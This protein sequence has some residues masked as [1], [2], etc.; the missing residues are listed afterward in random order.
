MK[1]FFLLIAVVVLLSSCS[2]KKGYKVTVQYPAE[3]NEMGYLL[4]VKEGALV[5]VDSSLYKGNFVFNGEVEQPEMYY[6]KT[7]NGNDRYNFFVENK[8]FTVHISKDENKVSSEGSPINKT[9]EQ[10]LDKTSIFMKQMDDLNVAYDEA[11]VNDKISALDSINQLADKIEMEEKEVIK[12][13]VKEHSESIVSLYLLRRKLSYR[14]KYDELNGLLSLIPEK[15]H[16]A[17]YYI[18]LDDLLAKMAKTQIGKVAPDFTMSDQ[19]GNPISLSD[20]KGHYTLI[21][22]WASW[23]G[24]CRRANP[25]VVKIYN[26]FEPKGF[27][28]FGVSFDKSKEK[29]LKAIEDDGLVW[30]HVSDLKGWANEAGQMYGVNSIPRTILVDPEGKIVANGIDHIQLKK[31]LAEIYK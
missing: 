30:K 12:T 17:R 11:V 20:F 18:Y 4:T 27:R 19:D 22:F 25:H 21:D 9:Y 2:E 29:W 14:L 26:E 24:P 3:E 5:A 1:N 6:F 23:C 28:I 8:E 7:L 10:F 15:F 16:K 13:F 31:M